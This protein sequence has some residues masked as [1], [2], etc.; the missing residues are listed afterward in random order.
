M[1]VVA[2]GASQYAGDAAP[3]RLTLAPPRRR[4]A[5]LRRNLK[6]GA[7]WPCGSRHLSWRCL[8]SPPPRR[9]ES[10]HTAG[11]S[12]CSAS[13][14]ATRTQSTGSGVHVLRQSPKAL[15]PTPARQAP[16]EALLWLRRAV[17]QTARRH[18]FSWRRV[19]EYGQPEPFEVEPHQMHL[20][21]PGPCRCSRSGPYA[22]PC[23]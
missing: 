1:R 14:N 22:Q 4:A 21:P 13:P 17:R 6:R 11:G 10:A 23:P 3:R 2:C 8:S 16:N 19:G 20:L 18:H 15:L 5:A 12:L 9:R 7:I